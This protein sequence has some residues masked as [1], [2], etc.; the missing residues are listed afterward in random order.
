MKAYLTVAVLTL[1]LGG[2]ALTRAS[3]GEPP[4]SQQ[5]SKEASKA[6]AEAARK[7]ARARV[8]RCKLHPEICRQKPPP[9]ANTLR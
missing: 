1:V 6:E 4:A 5:E 2:G 7:A 3:A 8:A 9:R